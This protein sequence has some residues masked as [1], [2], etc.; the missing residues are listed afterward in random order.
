MET[1]PGKISTKYQANDQLTE[2]IDDPLIDLPSVDGVV[3]GGLQMVPCALFYL[4]GEWEIHH[5]S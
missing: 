1:Y 3:D 4:G 5:T 2:A